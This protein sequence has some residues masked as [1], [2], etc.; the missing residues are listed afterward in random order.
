MILCASECRDGFPDHVKYKYFL[1]NGTCAQSILDSI[2]YSVKVI[3]D[4]W[5]VQIQAQILLKSKV[6]LYSDYL[7]DQDILTAGL[8]TVNEINHKIEEIVNEL[9]EKP[10][11]CVLP[12]GPQTIPFIN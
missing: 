12:E 8:N 4:Q 10:Y 7:N 6:Y 3:Q 11:I 9:G 5:Q 2:V 1:K